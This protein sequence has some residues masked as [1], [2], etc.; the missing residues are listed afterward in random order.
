M[1]KV[2][3]GRHTT[4][5]G[6]TTTFPLNQIP[7]PFVDSDCLFWFERSIKNFASNSLQL[8]G[9][10]SLVV[11]YDGDDQILPLDISGTAPFLGSS[12]LFNLSSDF[13]VGLWLKYTS[14]SGYY[15]A[16]FGRDQS[17]ASSGWS[18]NSWFNP[19]DGA[20]YKKLR[21]YVRDGSSGFVILNQTTAS[22]FEPNQWHLFLLSFDSA[23]KTF[24]LYGNNALELTA[25]ASGTPG[26]V[27]SP[28]FSLGQWP[29][30]GTDFRCEGKVKQLVGFNKILS[31]AE[32][33]AL[34]NG[35]SGLLYI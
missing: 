5:G 4:S 25:I 33:S 13:T 28:N 17:G 16:L 24:Y 15:F 1:A 22:A 35:G 29:G 6:S 32:R 3:K 7:S 11:G 12:S 10:A 2:I 27:S 14:S 34:W 9:G 26:V 19:S 20:N 30:G 8:N 31:G 23:A 21:L 18:L